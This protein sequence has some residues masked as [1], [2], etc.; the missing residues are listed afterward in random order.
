MAIL[1]QVKVA[2]FFISRNEKI[3]QLVHEKPL[4]SLIF[5]LTCS[6]LLVVHKAGAFH[7]KTLKEKDIN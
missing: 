6:F 1:R 5:I 4:S 7:D 2:A 3:C